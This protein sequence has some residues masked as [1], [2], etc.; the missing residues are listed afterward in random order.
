MAYFMMIKKGKEYK[1]LDIVSLDSFER[2]SY[3]KGN[4]MSLKEIDSFT[5]KFKNEIDFKTYLCQKGVLDVED[6]NREISIRR[7]NKEEY[8]KVRY[9]LVYSD[10]KKYLDPIYLRKEIMDKQNN[11]E[12]M[13]KLVDYYRSSHNGQSMLYAIRAI[14]TGL[15]DSPMSLGDALDEFITKE[16]YE[17]NIITGEAKLRYK[18]LHDMGMFLRNYDEQQRLREEKI[19]DNKVK[20]RKRVIR[21]KDEQIEGQTSLFEG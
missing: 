15:I 3:L 8:I 17:T 6:I 9:G 12:F 14:L 7:K 20:V 18:P 2:L 16:L 13:T 19:Q 5:S 4:S 21:D 1:K 10:D 11:I